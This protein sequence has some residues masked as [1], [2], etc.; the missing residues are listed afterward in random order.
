M[1]TVVARWES[2]QMS[3]DLEWRMWRQ[4]RGFGINRFVF[5]PIA[6]EHEGVNIE[7]YETMEEALAATADAGVRVFLEPGGEKTM[8]D[9]PS[10]DNDIVIILGNTE[11]SNA[12]F[13]DADEMYKITGVGRV[14]MYPTSAAAIALAY[15]VEQ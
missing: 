12:Q 4:L 6:P 11:N 3:A 10:R 15:W 5:T 1:V 9:L 14:D 13:A 2:S 8:N 7:Q